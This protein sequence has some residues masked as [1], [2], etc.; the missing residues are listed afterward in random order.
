MRKAH[1]FAAFFG[2]MFLYGSNST[3]GYSPPI[4]LI[5]DISTWGVEYVVDI[6]DHAQ[7]VLCILE[8]SYLYYRK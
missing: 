5:A 2:L 7:L 6:M 4:E 8:S 3:L 1:R